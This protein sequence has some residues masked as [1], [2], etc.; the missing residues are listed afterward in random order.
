MLQ[1]ISRGPAACDRR[2]LLLDHDRTCRRRIGIGLASRGFEPIEVESVKGALAA[3][4]HTAP[5]FAV[6]DTHLPEGSGLKVVEALRSA[7]PDA[8]VIVLTDYGSIASAVRAAKAGAADYLSKP[9]NADV[10]SK[11]LLAEASDDM[12]EPPA[13]PIS[14]SRVRW[15]HIQRVFELCEHNVSETARRLRMHRRTLQRI[16]GKKAPH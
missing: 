11:A 6:I 10:V 9:A 1:S 15:E 5:P 7:R 2:V 13:D 8:R 16:L 4:A 3:V 14:A 12:P